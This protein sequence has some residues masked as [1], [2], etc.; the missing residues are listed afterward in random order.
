MRSLFIILVSASLLVSTSA[1]SFAQSKKT[2]KKPDRP[3]SFWPEGVECDRSIPT[4]KQHFGFEVGFRH[5]TH[6]QIAS[7]AR[8]VANASDRVSIEKTGQTHGGRPLLLLTITSPENRERLGEIRD[9]HRQLAMGHK[10]EINTD[11]LPAV[12]N[13]GYGVHGDEPSATNCSPLVIHYLASAQSPAVTK[14]LDDCVVLLDPSL[15][16][17]GFNRFA[18]WANRYRGRVLN[19][20]PQ[21]AEHSQ[22]WPPGRVNYYWF[23]LNRDWLP[24]VHPES[25]NR[26]KWYH[27]WKPNVVL[28]FHE[29]GSNSTYFFQPGIPERTNPLTPARNVELTGKFA[30]YHARAL[31]QRGSLYYTQESFDDFYMGKGSTYPDLHGSVGIL[32][33]QASSRGHVQRNQDG[34]LKFHDTIAN[35][36]A[37]SLSSLQATTDLRLELHQHKRDFYRDALKMA[38]KSKIQTYVF[39]CPSNSSRLQEFA[40]T[41]LRHDIDCF[42]LKK[43]IEYG[44]EMLLAGKDLIVPASQPEFRFLKSLLMTRKSFKENIFYDVSAWTLPLAYGLN[45]QSLARPIDASKLTPCKISRSSATPPKFE[46]NDVAYLVDWRDDRAVPFLNR[47]L[48]NKIKVRVATKPLTTSGSEPARFPRGTLSI[49]LGV[50]PGKTELIKKLIRRA[51]KQGVSITAVKTGLTPIGIDLGSGNFPVIK[52]PNVAMLTGQP[53]SAYGAGEI[54]HHLDTRIGM[55]LTLIKHSKLGST[56]LDEYTTLIMPSGRYSQL[57]DKDSEKIREWTKAGGNLI[58]IG[59]SSHSVAKSIG[60]LKDLVFK[61]DEE[62]EEE[63]RGA[64]A[65]ERDADKKNVRNKAE[66]GTAKPKKRTARSKKAN[67]DDDSPIQKPFDSAGDTRA[68][69]LISGAIFKTRVD[70]THPLLYG[71]TNRALP[72]FRNHSTFLKPSKNRYNNPVVYDFDSPL[73]AGYCADEN[74]KRASGAA[75]VVVYKVGKG[76]IILMSDDPTFRGFWHATGR[77]LMNAIFFGENM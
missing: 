39:S 19:P 9:T 63:D 12:I 60:E 55:P 67:A 4:P 69:K 32:F 22:Q 2:N 5:L 66:E 27:A 34:L 1:A 36:F 6:A 33:E 38:A 62:K 57:N 15:N 56:D 64:D 26:M 11:D 49:P 17:D 74:L 21:H 23:D 18:N 41:L 3:T 30:K 16:P 40:N 43:D 24:L 75:S 51:A 8:A 53:V 20:D 10:D 52:R 61:T 25:R 73:L 44:D 71:F 13:M 46:K 7:Y 28:D 48:Q 35:Q 29:M 77:L 45:Q 54:W 59:Q 31:D 76:Q 58:A 42:W 50:Q 37:T 72:V 14:I 70:L 65:A 47:L 68:L